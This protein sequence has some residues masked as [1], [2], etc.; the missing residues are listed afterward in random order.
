VEFLQEEEMDINKQG[1]D[2]VFREE[3]EDAEDNGKE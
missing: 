3:E 1:G 2:C